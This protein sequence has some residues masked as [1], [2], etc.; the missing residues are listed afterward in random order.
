VIQEPSVAGSSDVAWVTC[1]PCEAKLPQRIH[2]ADPDD[3]P[4]ASG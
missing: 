1:A 2:D 3:D 4:G